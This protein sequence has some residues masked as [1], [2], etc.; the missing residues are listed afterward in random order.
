MP[1]YEYK[2]VTVQGKKVSGVQDGEGLKTVRAKLKKDGIVVLEIR[3]GGLLR[4]GRSREIT[5]GKGRVKLGDLATSTRQLATLLSAGLPLM[6]ALSVLVEQ[7]ESRALKSA[8]SSVRDA[9]REGA[10]LTDAL[11]GNAKT[12]SPLYINMVSAGEASGTLEIT[13]ARLADFLDEQVRF[14]GRFAAALAY[15]AL[16]VQ[17]RAAPGGGHVR[18]HEAAASLHDDCAPLGCAGRIEGVVGHPD[19]PWRGRLLSPPVSLHA[20]RESVV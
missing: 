12:F 6:E 18:G 3:E 16:P 19:S 11:K 8:L 4:A 20:C 2:G 17:F 10:S 7:E 1:V 5:F 13:L 15:P 14:R 9:V